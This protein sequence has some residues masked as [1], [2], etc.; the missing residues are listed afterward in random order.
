MV[1]EEGC[2]VSAQQKLSKC[3]FCGPCYVSFL[4]KEALQWYFCPLDVVT[5]LTKPCLWYQRRREVAV[6]FER[7]AVS[8]LQS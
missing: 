4:E 5:V 6:L 2:L 3:P 8:D 7:V 1:L